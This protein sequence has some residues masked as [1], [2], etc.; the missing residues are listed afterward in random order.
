MYSFRI[1]LFL[2]FICISSTIADDEPTTTTSSSSSNNI[3]ESEYGERLADASSYDYNSIASR[4]IGH[5]HN[6]H[7][8]KADESGVVYSSGINAILNSDGF[9]NTMN[10]LSGNDP[11]YSP[12][13]PVEAAVHTKKTIEVIPVRF[14]EPK[15]GEPQVIEISP[16]EVPLSIVFKTQTNKINV[17]QEHKSEMPEEVKETSSEEEPHRVVHN[18]YRPVIQEVT[19]IVQPYRKVLQKVEPV[20]EEMKTIITKASPDGKSGEPL[21]PIGP[22][23]NYQ[24]NSDNSRFTRFN[25][26]DANGRGLNYAPIAYGSEMVKKLESP[27]YLPS[28]SSSETENEMSRRFGHA[29]M[30]FCFVFYRTR[31]L[32][33]PMNG[34]QNKSSEHYNS[35]I[36][37]YIG[38]ILETKANKAETIS[39]IQ[40]NPNSIKLFNMPMKSAPKPEAYVNNKIVGN[41]VSGETMAQNRFEG[42]RSRWNNYGFGP[43]SFQPINRQQSSMI[44]RRIGD[45][46]RSRPR[47]NQQQQQQ[48]Q[49]QRRFNNGFS[50]R[51]LN[52]DHMLPQATNYGRQLA[53]MNEISLPNFAFNHQHHHPIRSLPVQLYS[54]QFR[55]SSE[56]AFF[57][58]PR[59]IHS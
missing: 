53:R 27:P 50:R 38:K 9:L 40:I 15:D 2:L 16:Y 34:N 6:Q 7:H 22:Q 26:N 49:H 30:L 58:I 19:E 35:I 54:P 39:P 12:S 44:N 17:N 5:H 42:S 31:L 48:P 36:N 55:R 10:K 28:S 57:N 8:Q 13:G 59:R 4:D 41:S 45:T 24:T 33:E 20:I 56:E 23:Q 18:V 29:S 43:N 37:D 1:L 25:G 21:Q 14:E 3:D 46:I 47:I 11:K 52:V 51:Q 32:D